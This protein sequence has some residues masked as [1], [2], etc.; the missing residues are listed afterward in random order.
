M[1]L[2][3]L[4][5][6]ERLKADPRVWDSRYNLPLIPEHN[7]PWTYLAYCVRL[8]GYRKLDETPVWFQDAVLEYLGKCTP[9]KESGFLYRWPNG[10][11]GSHDEVYGAAFLVRRFARDASAFLARNDGLYALDENPND[12]FFPAERHNFFRFL[13]FRPTLQAWSEYPVSVMSE[14][15][16]SL[17]VLYNAFF[18][19]PGEASGLLKIWLSY[20]AMQNY[21]WSKLALHIWRVRWES[22]GYTP[23]KIFSEVYLNNI[24]VLGDIAGDDLS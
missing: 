13:F 4:Q 18:V 22:R 5:K 17:H 23:K 12:Y 14:A 15:L 24:L 2:T 19:K 10:E 8:C 16:Y 6:L 1:S 20:P 7:N 9:P 21:K 11:R 3:P